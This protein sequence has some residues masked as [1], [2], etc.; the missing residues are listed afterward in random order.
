MCGIAGLYQ[1]RREY[2]RPRVTEIVDKMIS[3]IKHRGPD[4]DGV[5][6]DP[7]GRCGLGHRRLSIIDTSEAGRQPMASGDGQWQIT[8][9]GELYNFQE[10][11]PVLEQAG[12]A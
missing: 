10:V 12:I 2:E 9:N 3:T 11:K 7:K 6:T 8:F 4:A 1:W 5:W